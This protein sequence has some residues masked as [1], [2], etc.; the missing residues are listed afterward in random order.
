MNLLDDDDD[1]D[2][3]DNEIDDD[4][5]DIDHFPLGEKL[6]KLYFALLQASSL[7]NDDFFKDFNTFDKPNRDTLIYKARVVFSEFDIVECGKDATMLL[8]FD[9]P[10]NSL[11]DLQ[12][13]MQR[14]REIL[15]NFP[16][17]QEHANDVEGYDHCQCDTAI[18]YYFALKNRVTSQRVCPIG[19]VCIIKFADTDTARILTEANKIFESYYSTKEKKKEKKRMKEE[20]M[21]MRQH[22]KPKKVKVKK[23]NKRKKCASDCVCYELRDLNKHQLDPLLFN[24]KQ[25]NTKAYIDDMM[26]AMQIDHKTV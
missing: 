22:D 12:A 10:L 3:N 18:R 4:I 5:D 24:I 13:N 2:N 7:C 21:L 23:T 25:I 6:Q 11:K 17:E 14:I 20:L 15:M 16:D 9:P 19:R 1:N 8:T 26:S